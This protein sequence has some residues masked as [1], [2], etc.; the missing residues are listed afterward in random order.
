SK[1]YLIALLLLVGCASDKENAVPEHLAQIENLT[2]HLEPPTP[3]SDIEFIREISFGDTEEVLFGRMVENIAVDQSGKVFLADLTESTIHVFDFDGSYVQSIGQRGQGPGEFQ[4]IWDFKIHDEKIHVL[5]TQRF[6]ISV[7]DLN[8]F[9]H[10]RDYDISLND[11]QD[12][13]PS[14]LRW[15]REKGLFYRPT[16]IFIRSNGNYLLLFSDA[17]IGM[18][19]NVDGRTYEGSIY[20]PQNGEFKMHD[21]VSLD[22]TGQVLVHEEGDGLLVLFRVPYKRQS[23]FDF[24]NDQFVHGWSD[25]MLFRFHDEKGDYQKAF[26]YSYSNSEL[27]FDDLLKHYEDSGDNVIQAIRSDDH[28]E[29]WPAFHSLIFDDENRLWVS[30]MTDD[31]DSYEWWVLDEAG[32]LMATFSWP[33]TRDL[34]LVKDNYAYTLERDTETGLQEVVRYKITIRS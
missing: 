28:P 13:Q 1:V 4:A 7:F 26:Y 32:N 33:R 23:L 27:Q 21:V 14:W 3:T 2:A 5:D 6:S 9:D 24:S 34:K 25:E 19:N 12:N 18:A 11:E 29:T 22:W 15:T 8:T 31:Q 30:T 10:I 16:N 20:D 17:S